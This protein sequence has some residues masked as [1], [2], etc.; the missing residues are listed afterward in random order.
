MVT[1]EV[2]VTTQG[3][4]QLEEQLFSSSYLTK[5]LRDSQDTVGEQE[6]GKGEWGTRAHFTIEHNTG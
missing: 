6:V 4:S 5:R 2:K 3:S 1:N